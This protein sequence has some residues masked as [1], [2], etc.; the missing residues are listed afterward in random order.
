M[1]VQTKRPANNYRRIINSNK[2]PERTTT[3][4]TSFN[5]I[6]MDRHTRYYFIIPSFNLVALVKFQNIQLF[7]WQFILN[8]VFLRR[9]PIPSFPINYIKPH[10]M[11]M[12][13]ELSFKWT[14]DSILICNNYKIIPI[15]NYLAKGRP[16]HVAVGILILFWS[17]SW[18]LLYSISVES[19]F[20]C[21][22]ILFLILISSRDAV[23]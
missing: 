8:H 23:L 7:D 16:Y 9:W 3:S 13:V 5:I 2:K 18:N 1:T 10:F 22:C 21:G 17:S 4:S 14:H 6:Q 19:R 20:N 15:Q 11:P 12:K